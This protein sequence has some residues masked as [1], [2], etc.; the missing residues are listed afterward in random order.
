MSK[1]LTDISTISGTG[2]S[3]TQVLVQSGGTLGWADRD[4]VVSDL[5]EA[6]EAATEA[7]NTATASGTTVAQTYAEELYA[8]GVEWDVTASS[9]TVTRIGNS[10]YHATLP[11]QSLMKGC[12]LADDGTVNAYLG[13]TDWTSYD[14]TGASGQVMVEIPA[15]YRKFVTDGDTRQV[16]ISLVAIEG[17][18]LVP[19]MYISA[20][21][22]ALDRT[23]LV[24][25]SVANSDE[26]YIGGGGSS[27]ETSY[28]ADDYTLCG[29]PATYITRTAMRTYA[30][31]RG[32]YGLNG[33][34]WNA[35]TWQ[36]HKTLY[37]LY[38]IEYANRNSQADYNS[39]LTSDGYHQGG[40]GAGV[41][42]LNSTYWNNWNAYNPFVPCGYTDSLGNQTGTVDFDMPSGYLDAASLSS[43]T[44]SVPRYR[45]IENP[46][47]HIW[48]FTDGAIA[49][50]TDNQLYTVNEATGEYDPSLFSST[51]YSNY[52]YQGDFSTSSSV[53][54]KDI[55]FGEYGEIV[56][57]STGGSAT[58]YYCDYTYTSASNSIRCLMVGGAAN[59]GTYA[60]LAYVHSSDAF[61]YSYRAYCSRLCF[62]PA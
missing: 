48:K 14:R 4:D 9:P 10:T 35:Y 44:V 1:K 24:L 55:L 17:Y 5:I 12:L 19:K 52:Q 8:Y 47:G 16:W 22:A 34:G 11:V 27:D 33:A 32:S 37:W 61:S 59:Y 45:G 41:T 43:L 7:L 51:S 18:H 21:E 50:G 15:H 29:L 53:Y 30:R 23:N 38:V 31:N 36:A 26:Q 25:C 28:A 54:V 62:Y 49:Y 42:T 2:S 39:E 46:F 20:Y 13:A 58:T 3:S 6:T 56:G 57:I 60:G 40:L